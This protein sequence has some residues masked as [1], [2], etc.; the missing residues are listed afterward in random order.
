MYTSRT[1]V[2]NR[3]KAELENHYKISIYNWLLSNNLPQNRLLCQLVM[4]YIIYTE[5]NAPNLKLDEL[6]P[7]LLT[8]LENS[9]GRS[10]SNIQKELSVY[11]KHFLK[12][13]ALNLDILNPEETYKK[14]QGDKEQM[15]NMGFVG[16]PLVNAYS[17]S[18]PVEKNWHINFYRD[19]ILD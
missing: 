9:T 8:F 10:E 6:P 17:I 11:H 4:D 16:E 3:A 13:K 5:G 19:E 1:N 7:V 15:L 2:N 14:Y 12:G 18:N